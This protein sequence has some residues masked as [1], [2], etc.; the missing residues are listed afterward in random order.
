MPTKHIFCF[1]V[2][3][4]SDCMRFPLDMLRYD[5]C[6]PTDGDSAMEIGSSFDSYI[7]KDRR[8]SYQR[9]SVNLSSTVPP[10]K[11]RWQSFGWTVINVEKRRI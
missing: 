3:S 10:T 9:F 8:E 4:N 2:R 11:E 1:T 5:F 6:Y 7:S